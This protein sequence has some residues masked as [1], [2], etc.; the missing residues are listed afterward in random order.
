[1][2]NEFEAVIDGVNRGRPKPTKYTERK[3]RALR[4][5]GS[6]MEYAIGELLDA[7]PQ[8]ARRFIRQVHAGEI[9]PALFHGNHGRR[10]AAYKA[11]YEAVDRMYGGKRSRGYSSVAICRE[12]A[13]MGIP[14]PSARTVRYWV[15]H[16][17]G[18]RRRRRHRKKAPPGT[19]RVWDTKPLREKNEGM[20]R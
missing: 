5:V 10:N 1:M 19:L 18:K 17:F 14:V 16:D 4:F 13:T 8:T 12:L 15:R 20:L 3:L 9:F 11:A 2:G 6:R 7:S